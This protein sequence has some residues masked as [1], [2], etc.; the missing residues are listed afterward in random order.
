MSK[1]TLFLDRDGVINLQIIGGYVTKVDEFEFLPR[2]LEA[3]S[4]LSKRFDYI[5]IVTNQQGIGKGVF[6]M[7]DLTGIHSFMLDKIK[8]RGGR[9]DK[10]YVSPYLETDNNIKRKPNAGM[11]LQALAEFPDIDLESAVMVGDS[12][13]DMQFGE[14]LGI[15]TV[16]L[17]NGKP[18]DPDVYKIT[19]TVFTDLF[20][21]SRNYK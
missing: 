10:I 16:Y 1:K 18:V 11:G 5:F 7:N 17:S 9:I 3:L 14:N 12:L 6:S 4:N 15:K 8:E 19:D 13:P 21:F 20:D 2:V